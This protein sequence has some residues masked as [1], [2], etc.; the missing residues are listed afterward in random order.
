[1]LGKTKTVIINGIVYSL[2]SGQPIGRLV[3]ANDSD[4]VDKSIIVRKKIRLN[5]DTISGPSNINLEKLKK[6][7]FD[8]SLVNEAKQ[9]PIKKAVVKA[10]PSV[11]VET[12]QNKP[13]TK[14]VP[15]KINKQKAK[16][17]RLTSKDI[18]FK[19]FID[20]FDRNI[21]RP[22]L[23]RTLISFRLF[24]AILLPVLIIFVLKLPQLSTKDLLNL[25]QYFIDSL[26][27]FKVW[28]II[29][30]LLTFLFISSVTKNL[31][32]QI[33]IA[34]MVNKLS[35]QKT[36]YYQIFAHSKKRLFEYWFN[37]FLN[38]IWFLT[39]IILSFFVFRLLLG[40]NNYY[41]EYSKQGILNVL[42]I[43]SSLLLFLVFL[44][45]ILQKIILASTDNKLNW[46]QLKGYGL[47]SRNY[48][49]LLASGIYWLILTSLMMALVAIAIVTQINYSLNHH[50]IVSRIIAMLIGVAIVTSILSLHTSWSMVYWSKIYYDL[51]A[52]TRKPQSKLYL[53]YKKQIRARFN[54]NIVIYVVLAIMILVV[55]SFIFYSNS[56]V[57]SSKLRELNQRVNSI[58]FENIIPKPGK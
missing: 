36:S 1:M 46:A 17:I 41:I 28:A 32:T 44:A 30:L 5:I 12:K 21:L 34:Y 10:K 37:N 16:L 52:K 58:N 47:A 55:Y 4:K 27:P 2:S 20:I 6:T 45:N 7:N 15:R 57:V 33:S 19:S 14:M 23:M 49:K 42:V 25:S 22:S 54:K 3:K 50:D 26:S 53:T 48:L 43:T 29:G 24:L 8:Y 39:I 31:T 13:S 38:L 11:M 35:R 56:Y 40:S 18:L 51:I 9:K